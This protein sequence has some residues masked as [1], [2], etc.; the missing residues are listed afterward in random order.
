[1]LPDWTNERA[2]VA[3]PRGVGTAEKGPSHCLLRKG[4]LDNRRLR[5]F[6]SLAVA[7]GSLAL[8]CLKSF[9][10]V[11]A[12]R[13]REAPRPLG[14]LLHESVERRKRAGNVSVSLERVQQKTR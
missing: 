6:G 2:A 12:C 5:A 4:G 14:L 11:L 3:R 7:M 10:W 8:Q 13:A 1:M 9:R